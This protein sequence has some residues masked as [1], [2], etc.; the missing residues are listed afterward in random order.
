MSTITI[1]KWIPMKP[2]PKKRPRVTSNGTYTPNKELYGQCALLFGHVPE[3]AMYD[4]V[5]KAVRQMPQSWSQ[6]RRE[7]MRGTY[8]TAVPDRDNVLGGVMDALFA[9]DGCVVNARS[10]QVWGDEWGMV[11]QL[12][13]LADGARPCEDEAV[14]TVDL[15]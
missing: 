10:Y 3:A 13:T 12:T 1:T 4:L 15:Y 9:S 11:V 6:K 2:F 14:I 8:A 5:V 7:A